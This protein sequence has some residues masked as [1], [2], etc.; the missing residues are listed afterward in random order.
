[1]PFAAATPPSS[2]NMTLFCRLWLVSLCARN[3]T[4]SS[5]ME[6]SICRSPSLSSCIEAERAAVLAGVGKGCA[7]VAEG[8]DWEKDCDMWTDEGGVMTDGAGCAVE[9]GPP[10]DCELI[11]GYGGEVGVFGWTMGGFVSLLL[12][13]RW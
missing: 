3:R 1:M 11:E 13:A 9:A 4:A 6:S 12:A 8:P 7:V 2:A 10:F 5:A